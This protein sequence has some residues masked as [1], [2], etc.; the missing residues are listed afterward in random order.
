MI[1]RCSGAIALI[2][3]SLLAG[4]CGSSPNGPSPA[5]TLTLSCPANVSTASP[6][7]TP[8]AVTF[9]TP[10]GGGGTAPITTTCTPNSGSQF[11]V[12]TSAVSCQAR[13]AASRT[14]SCSFNVVVTAPPRLTVTRFLA[15]GDSLTYGVLSATPTFLIV[16]PPGSYPFQLE[17][18]LVARYPQQTP[19]IINEGNPGEL[20]SGTGVQRFRSVLLANRPEVVL[21]MQGTNDLLFGET[22]ASNAIDALRA[23]VREA[24]S[25]GLRIALAT[26][27]PQRAGGLRNR[28][29]VVRLI[30]GFNDRVRGLAGA[31][32][33]PVIE[34][35]N[36]MQ[37]DNTLIG[38]DDLHM[39]ERGYEVMAD[40]YAEAIRKNY[41]IGTPAGFYR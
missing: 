3:M 7:G 8:R 16:S 36:G 27:P 12:G 23:M 1:R 29:A 35:F 28:D 34:V 15:F 19:V 14:A 18:R 26:I 25:Q 10:Q 22:G 31:E 5:P 9:D 40:I 37:G 33:I 21:L 4:A 2:T 24:K 11:P 13:D 20:A 32:Q 6:D 30:P 39:T 38:V 17:R 41:E